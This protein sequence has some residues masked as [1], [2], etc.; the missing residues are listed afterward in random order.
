[1]DLLDSLDVLVHL[2][3]V[4]SQD[5]LD[6]LVSLVPLEE[7]EEQVLLEELECQAPQEARVPLEP[8]AAW[9]Q[10]EELELLVEGAL[11]VLQDQL[12]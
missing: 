2:E 6:Q 12:V 7:L 3:Q 4:V 1:M 8:Q 11:E 5:A 10:L 9:D